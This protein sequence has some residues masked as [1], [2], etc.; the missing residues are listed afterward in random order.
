MQLVEFNWGVLRYD[1]DDP[2][3]A[4]FA[5][6]LDRVNQIA[7]RSDGFIWRL[8]DDDME[9]AQTDPSGAM[10]GN[11]RFASTLSVWRDFKSLD[12]FVWN[13]LHKHFFARREE[14]FAPGQ[15]LRLVMW[16]VPEGEIP[17]IEEAVAR[18]EHLKTHGDSADAFG[19]AYLVQQQASGAG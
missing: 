15:G 10:G 11:P 17:T 1:W 16:W 5:N 9:A 6:G 13:T 8:G 18:A 2:R 19:W 12:H 7:A 3:V 14:W 4:D